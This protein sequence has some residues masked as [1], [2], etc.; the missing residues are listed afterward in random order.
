M[1]FNPGGFPFAA[2]LQ[3]SWSDLREECLAL[4]AP[5]R[6][7][8]RIGAVEGFAEMLLANN[9]WTPSWQVGSDQANAD[10]L[11]FGLSYKG[12]LPDRLPEMMPKTSRLL[13]RLRGSEVCALSLMK[14][15][16]FILPHR[17]PE[18]EGRL[19]TLHLGLH[20]EPQRS[21]LCVG[22]ETREEA[23]G[24]VILFNAGREHFAVNMG[25]TNRII[26]YL[27]FDPRIAA[28]ES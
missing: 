4:A 10:W 20:V 11:T 23:E 26:L 22:G 14:P 27:E 19:L 21:Y 16:T 28:F 9:G 17:H 18:L 3:R 8:H 2:E 24:R 12:M 15:G 13:A 7:V 25:R 5:M 1:F 6:D